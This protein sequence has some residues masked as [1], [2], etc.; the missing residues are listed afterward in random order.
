MKR[1][2]QGG[3]AVNKPAL[4]RRVDCIRIPVDNLESALAFYRDALGLEPV[5]R[6]GDSAGLGMPGD[7][8]EIVIHTRGGSP[9]T[10]LLVQNADEAARVIVE[11][12]GSVK[13]APFD[14]RIGRCCVVSDPWGN[15]LVLLDC[16]KGLLVTDEHG[17]V[18]G[19]LPPG[20]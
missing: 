1:A 5:W 15:E 13:V 14:I 2:E 17:N 19:N 20:E 4:L 18:T 9:E 7:G 8:T 11:A 10:D 3:A 6:D 12:G 16:S